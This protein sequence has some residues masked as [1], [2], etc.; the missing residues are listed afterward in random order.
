[1]LRVTPAASILSRIPSA[2]I[3]RPSRSVPMWACASNTP[4]SGGILPRTHAQTSSIAPL[5]RASML[6][7]RSVSVVKWWPI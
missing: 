5:V 7:L 2:V 6:C 4:R 1:M 3:V